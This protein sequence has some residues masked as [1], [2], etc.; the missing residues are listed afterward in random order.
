[1]KKDTDTI[2][3][4]SKDIGL[5]TDTEKT[6]VHFHVKSVECRMKSQHKDCW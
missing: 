5:E 1:M 3:V 2:L 6:S 4:T